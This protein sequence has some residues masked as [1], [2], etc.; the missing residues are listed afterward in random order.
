M[1]ALAA[2][3][4][5]TPVLAQTSAILRA[6]AGLTTPVVTPAAVLPPVAP[7][8]PNVAGMTSASARALANQ[9]AAT[10]AT[11]LAVQANA[12]ARATAQ[13]L[14][15]TVPNGL[16]A[17]GLVPVANAVAAA[18]DPTGLRTWQG[19]SAPVQS[20]SAATPTVTIT[21]TASRALLTWDSFNI[22]RNTTLEFKQQP[23]WVVV[24]RIV[25]N[26]DPATGRIAN[27]AALRPSQILG[28]IKAD[29]TV[30]VI[31]QNG[32]LFGGTA[33]INT[34][35]FLASS[36]E[37][38]AATRETQAAGSTL[39]IT[40]PNSIFERSIS[41]LQS[42]LL[43]SG[44]L[45][46]AVVLPNAAGNN[47]IEPSDTEGDVR[48]NAGASINSASGGYVIIAAPKVVNAGQLSST[49]GQVSLQS[50]RQ[51]LVSTS[52]GSSDSIDPEVRGLLLSSI[53]SS[54]DSISNEAT[55]LIDAKRGY[56]S[57]GSAVTGEVSNAGVLN[58]T[59]SVTRNGK[60]SITGS[61]VT[62]AT[63]STIVITPDN[64]GETIP[65]SAESV[66]AFKRSTINIGG[67][68][69]RGTVSPSRSSLASGTL[70]YA[71]SAKVNIGA[72]ND[73]ATVSVLDDSLS[74]QSSLAIASGATI[75][76]GGIKDL[77]VPAS[78]NSI[79]ISP[80]KRNELRDTPNY[81]ET[82]T[83]NS[84]T[85]NGAT[86]FVD[87][88]LSGVRADGVAWIG[89][90]LIEAGSFFAQVGVT[91]AE[92][93]TIG[94][95]LTLGVRSFA[96]G[97]NIAPASV[98]VDSGA[99]IDVSG[100]W[101][102]YEDGIVQ[103][104]RLRTADGRIVEIG[105]ADPNE[106]YVAVLD[107]I[108]VSQSRFGFTESFANTAQ[109][110]NFQTGYT[111]GRDAGSLTIKASTNSFG[112]VL[113]G[114]AFAGTRQ[115][116][117]AREASKPATIASDLR[118]LQAAPSQLPSGGLLKIA[119]IGTNTAEQAGGADIIVYGGATAPMRPA[120]EILLSDAFLSGAGLSQVALQ[121]SGRVSFQR[122]SA[123]TLQAGGALVVDAG[124]AINFDG[125]ISIAS[126]TIAARTY[127]V[128]PGS[129]F[130]SDDELPAVL[131][132]NLATPHLFDITVN[133]LLST[134]GRWTNDYLVS[135]GVY[136]GSA[137]AD[138]GSISLEVAPRV[139]VPV[140]ENAEFSADL[141][142]SLYVNASARIDVSGGGYVR[143]D[144]NLLIDS[145]GGNVAL[146]NQTTYSQIIAQPT[147][148]DGFPARSSA[149]D[150]PSFITT[151]EA[152]RQSGLAPRALESRVVIA[153][154]TIAGHGFS[155]GGNFTLVTPDLNFGARAGT[156]GTSLALDFVTKSGFGSFSLT[157][158]PTRLLSNVFSN[159]IGG[160]NAILDTEI[161]R[162]GSGETLNL[163]QSVINSL[164]VDGE[165]EAARNLVSGGDI[166]GLLGIAVPVDAFD[167]KAVDISFGGLTEVEIAAGGLVTG[168]NGASLSA[169]KLLNAGTIRISGGTVRQVAILPAAFVDTQRPAIG[170]TDL[171]TVFGARDANGLFNENADNALGIRRSSAVNAPVA[172]NADLVSLG[173]F[174]RPVYFTG[175]LAANEGIRLTAGSVTDLSGASIRNPRA[176]SRPGGEQKIDGRIVNGGRLETAARFVGAGAV[177][178]DVP[179]FGI[180]PYT[181]PQSGTTLDLQQSGMLLNAR[182]GATID[183]RGASDRYDFETAL[184]VFTLSPVW[185]DGGSLSLGSGGSL[186]GARV[187]ADGGAASAEGGVL[188][189]LD[190][191]LR[192]TDAPGQAVN[193][194][195]AD[196]IAAAG[197]DT[198]VAQNRLTTLG[199]ATLK[200]GR[201]FYLEARPFDG[202]GASIDQYRAVL[203]TTGNLSIEAPYIHLASPQQ[204]VLFDPF[205]STATG[206]ITLSGQTIDIIGSVYADASVANLTLNATGDVRLSG[207]QSPILTLIGTSTLPIASALSG[208]FVV[209]GDLNINAAQMYPTTGTGSLQ[210]DVNAQRAGTTAT[211]AP[212]VVASTGANA[213][214]RVSRAG[215]ST[216]ATPFSAGGNLLIQAANIVQDG[217]IRV[218]LGRLAIG[219]NT[220]LTLGS[221]LVSQVVPATRS[222]IIGANSTTSVS[223]NGLN[224]PYGTT[225]DLVEY[226]FTPTSDGRLFAP[227]AAELRLSGDSVDVRS[228]ASVDAT[229]G[230][231]LYAYEFAA[232][233]GGSR[234]VLS[235]FN[236]DPF[237]GN[238][239]FQ[240]AD[241]RQVYAIVPSLSQAGVALVDPVYSADYGALYNSTDAGRRVFLE[242]AP[243]LAAGW[244]T[245]LPAR[246]ALLPGGM[247]VVENVGE[248]PPALGQTAQ[249]RDG[250]LIVGGRY[251][252]T[253]TTIESSQRRT[254]TVQSQE[255]FRK[256]SN[257]QLTQASSTF[258]GLA[259]R[260]NLAVPRLPA[261]A[262]RL[263][264]APLTALAIN[265][266]F[267]TSPATGG[268]G[269]QVDISGNAFEIVVP[270]SAASPA[271]SIRLT[272]T[273]FSNLNAASLL[274]G[275][276][277]TENSNGTTALLV[278]SKSILVANNTANPLTAPEILLAVDG[279]DSTIRIAD[280][281]VISAT[282]SLND[283]SFGDYVITASTD[284]GQ[285]GIG[286]VMRL[287]NGAERL[288]SRPGSLAQA[289]SLEESSIT[290]GEARLTGQS[291]LLD[292]SRDL[293]IN[294]DPL[295]PGRAEIIATASLA[296]AGDDVFFTTAP[297]GYRGLVITPELEAQFANAEHLRIT[298]RSIIGF[299]GGTHSFKDLTID[300]RGVR[301][302]GQAITPPPKPRETQFDVAAADLSAPIGVTINARALKLAN[303][304]ISRT[305]CGGTATVTSCGETGNTLTVNATS[306]SFGSGGI[307]A[308]G[309][310]RNVLLSASQGVFIE[311]AATF[312]TGL[313]D[314]NVRSPYFGDRALSAD[315]RG[316]KVQPSLGVFTQGAVVLS[317]AGPA[318][319]A[320]AQA[321]GATL[322]FGSIDRPVA[323]FSAAGIALR[324]SAGV[325]DV[326]AVGDIVTTGTTVLATPGYSKTFGDAA[327][328]V[329]VSAP[330]GTL[331]LVSTRGNVNLGSASTLSIGGG[332]GNAGSLRLS[333]GLGTVTLPGVIEAAAPD[334]RA[335]LHFDSGL[336]G[337]DLA[338]FLA[339]QGKAFSGDIGIRTGVGNLTLNAGQ[340]LR[341]ESLRLTADGGRVDIAGTVD[342][343]GINGGSIG[344]FG[345]TGVTLQST[346]LLDSHAN[347]YPADDTR[348]ATGG[349]VEIGTVGTGNIVVASGARI[350]VAARRP[351]ARLI[352]QIRKDAQTL[353]D[354]LTYNYAQS[355]VG[356]T[357]SFRAPIVLTEVG[358]QS[359]NIA[360]AGTILGASETSVEGYRIFDLAT[361]ANPNGCA[362][363][364]ICINATGQAVLDLN[365]APLTNRL[366]AIAPG[367]IPDFIRSF[368]LSGATTGLGALLDD[369]NFRARPGV[370]L[371]YAGDIVLASN[372]NLAAATVN[373]AAATADGLIA[374]SVQLGNGLSY[375][376]PGKEAELFSG[377]S[378]RSQIFYTDFVYRVGG[379]ASGEAGVLTLRAGGNLDIRGSIT[380]GL[381]N[382]ADSTDPT[383]LSFQLGGGD[384]QYRPALVFNCG[385]F[386]SCGDLFTAFEFVPGATIPT[387]PAIDGVNI[388]I[389]RLTRG[390]DIT[391]LIGSPVAPYSAAA[392]SPGALGR[393]A[394]GAGDPIGSAV[395]MP[396]LADG[397]AAASSSLRLVGGAAP[398]GKTSLPVSADPLA[399]APSSTGSVI[400]SG[401]ATYRAAP[402]VVAQKYAGD[403]ELFNADPNLGTSVSAPPGDFIEALAATGVVFDPNTYTRL[404]LTGASATIRSFFV[405]SARAFFAANNIPANQ[406]QFFGPV[407]NP[408]VLTASADL[409]ARFLQSVSRDF[410]G[411]IG[412]PGFSY[413]APVPEAA[414]TLDNPNIATRSL[415][416]T[417]TG[418]IDIVA[419]RDVDLTNGRAVFRAVNGRNTSSTA[420]SGAQVGGAAVYTVGHRVDPAI[421]TATAVG[422]TAAL[423]IDPA[424]LAAQTATANFT[425]NL[426]GVLNSE[427]VYASGGGDIRIA[428][429]RDVIARRD[430]W[431]EAFRRTAA[432]N[433]P[434]PFANAGTD[435]QLWR[436]ISAPD[437]NQRFIP[438]TNIRINAQLFSTGVGAL[439]GGSVLIDAGRNISE[440][441]VASDTS[442]TTG[443][444]SNPRQPTQPA[445]LTLISF[446]GGNVEMRAGRDVL[447]AQVDV[448][449]G[450]LTIK[451]GNAVA[452]AGALRLAGTTSSP[453]APLEQNL[454]RVRLADATA[455][456][457][458]IK[459]V[460]IGGIASTDGEGF[461]ARTSGVSILT[462]GDALITNT[463]KDIRTPFSQNNDTNANLAGA[464]LPGS[465]SVSA[466]FGDINLSD[467]S[468]LSTGARPV[469]IVLV[470]SA[471]GQLRLFAGGH[472]APVT[473]V[474]DDGDPSL[475]PGPLSALTQASLLD[476]NTI[477]PNTRRFGVPVILPNTSDADRRLLHNERTTHAGD[478]EPV[479]IAADGNI[480]QLSLFVPKQ[481]RITA[482]GDIVDAIFV[483]QNLAANDVTR[484][485]AG[486]DIVASSRVLAT[487]TG[488]G[489][490]NLP[491]L[492]GN[493][494]VLGGPGAFFVEA[495]RDLG[496]FFNSA[497]VGDGGGN[498]LTYGG[499][500]L[501][502]GNDYNP[503]LQ[504][505]GAKLY[506]AFGVGKGA[507]YNALLSAYVDPAAS[508]DGDLFVQVTD[509]NGNTSPD[510]SKPI[511]DT[512]LVSW[513]V[514]NQPAAITAAFGAPISLA[515]SEVVPLLNSL[516]PAALASFLIDLPF[517]PIGGG[518]NSQTV[519]IDRSVAT[520]PVLLTGTAAAG[521]PSAQRTTISGST[522]IG[523]LAQNA[524]SVLM[525][526]YGLTS[527]D[528]NRAFAQLTA[529]PQLT[530]RQ[531]LL[532]RVYFNELAAPSRPDGAS[533]GQFIRGYRAVDLVFP[534]AS[535]YT[536]NDLAGAVNGGTKV[537]TGNLDLRLATLETQRGGD[538]T[539]LGPGGRVLG[540]SI[541]ATATQASRRGANLQ[542]PFNLFRGTRRSSID[543]ASAA[544]ILG[545]P[546]GFEGVLTLR[547]G[548]VRGFTDSDFLLNQSRLFTVGGGDITL[549]SSNG[550]LNA[551][552]G[553]KTSSNNPPVVVRFD[554]NGFGVLDQAGA[555]AGAGIAGFQPAGVD[556]GPDVT[557][558]A[559]V[560]T[561]D[562]GDAGVRAS[563]NVFVAAARV[564]N[565]DNFKVG[566]TA[567][568][569]IATTVVDTG[570]AASA[571][572]A[573]AAASQ[574]AAAVN[575]SSGR[576]GDDRSRI[577]VEVLGFAGSANDDPC[578]LPA[579]QRPGNCPVV[580]K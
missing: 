568:G 440:L 330:G 541:V 431:S 500:I 122:S 450:A 416:R 202:N 276:I 152:G 112:G 160:N 491:V 555:V 549:W 402:I 473:L 53:G 317:G 527:T 235:R 537:S 37:I 24:N 207:V 162:I 146:I 44:S 182:A 386:V 574:A 158:Y 345:L 2:A 56:I 145:K 64:N 49:E 459:T 183:V 209:A 367:T 471:V 263:V 342:T 220:P 38:G 76:V 92:L 166:A 331:S 409:M 556:K 413:A 192:Q 21:Q 205:S 171:G 13:A 153:P 259:T 557:L 28:T 114:D 427:P 457:S 148:P 472:L 250:S 35:S 533:S 338:A 247:R 244:Y 20:G 47:V 384:R 567:F 437:A 443:L 14:A 438:I 84:F 377:F 106:V 406:Y 494:F 116:A 301:P 120:S 155:G 376:V 575:P 154:G 74:L 467:T 289:N 407:N 493:N 65:Q 272:T 579:G 130:R 273:D 210:Q 281:A 487:P 439:G 353:N 497:I 163:T 564:A 282:G 82:T 156:S 191:V 321:P 255:T 485:T 571:N 231:D 316:T 232:G 143:P 488:T 290:I 470:P 319:T 42:G 40:V 448:A 10:N 534:G 572:A 396:L 62:L 52:S 344:L 542:D 266:R 410:A 513:L 454:L 570:A 142:G 398:E 39:N 324:A 343:S 137:Y 77:V 226:L 94:G 326:R 580:Q 180:A 138:G 379:R 284:T 32:I 445:A 22:G 490:A 508:L 150:A 441:T 179:L 394:N 569:N 350:D 532:D 79:Q 208:Q 313:A 420:T 98:M 332:S 529:L 113:H 553:V 43:A 347:G 95:D 184:G 561:V 405:T 170:V 195:S 211:A 29:G 196:Q 197:F 309:F 356:G 362:S 157:T 337:L 48:I 340:T 109:T 484:I 127:V 318:L 460:T 199:N 6:S 418:A 286:G 50:G 248:T 315:P 59:T 140:G 102:R 269:A 227:P 468:L 124:R 516:D 86:L 228:G 360:Y 435:T 237:S 230:G 371:E 339:G 548:S 539:I 378:E 372:W 186:N 103:T 576:A 474:M 458:A 436:S 425:P 327:D 320:V 219:S 348:A 411:R 351:G 45:V 507:N 311:G 486:G 254:F 479:R 262:A 525:A 399:I 451:A 380:D 34:R 111:E 305:P 522:L 81:R 449:S 453:I 167:R 51:V 400:V 1:A 241:G 501:T 215:T 176:G 203:S 258:S 392:N 283:T 469:P 573:S 521:A 329:I 212:Y 323:S 559:P 67:A 358:K 66:A 58:S 325:L 96:Q 447:G 296:I 412:A 381:F 279:V 430:A 206:R 314:L 252:I 89:S 466:L 545:I 387:V 223:A 505:A 63:G 518:I 17:G 333:A 175:S 85:L 257:I 295:T 119:A 46:S 69:V 287:A 526:R 214:I 265:T 509:E 304:D 270:G 551:G 7:V 359:V 12:A 117:D 544:R 246:Y 385:A 577:T 370:Q 393:Q 188:T 168:S 428:S 395:I 357:V 135:N 18:L 482:G 274:I 198:F 251:G 31:N 341:A 128:V 476:I 432:G 275:G 70:I 546:T 444:V 97:S 506:V 463:G 303:S 204:Q 224:I 187:F 335:S 36:L 550:D 72:T 133:G 105:N 144:G 306:I 271:G 554:P 504:P 126:G 57:M 481:A 334:G 308:F 408:T 434:T 240:F 297:S 519:A 464:L 115:I 538:I 298:T 19:A 233:I 264:L 141:S 424:F 422:S 452:S 512:A 125:S 560:G 178:A 121:T 562:A 151:P 123:L 366:A 578:N 429:G 189:W 181:N 552:Q 174:S 368:N 200:L 234:D 365:A 201:G 364:D 159:G 446:G 302:Y 256:F 492:Q 465:F 328:Q 54:P 433:P 369:P 90:P 172:T 403:L 16:V 299:S 373:V 9:V 78:R 243:G 134:R 75:D 15:Q 426:Q 229:G 110:S 336:G 310:D 100:G 165:I 414:T 11:S 173:L 87:P 477:N 388:V 216:P 267:L 312:D 5:H 278:T 528:I 26:I 25:A 495:G 355:D 239:G 268:R 462:N 531:F 292:S 517:L 236:A 421:Q 288:V 530:Q 149:V 60:I 375:V 389:S 139:L 23:D 73:A 3:L 496:P 404:T 222:T 129:V 383:Y 415:I 177:F 169:T 483:G 291:I 164:L 442:V 374:P 253:G 104:S 524:P 4:F 225:T 293:I 245:L 417:G 71:P 242:A 147:I 480:N 540:G 261:D 566:G 294:N 535:G 218:P 80:A 238:D 361:M 489:S 33:Q 503:W 543:N 419:A 249:L 499:G 41:Y 88:R 515:S 213:I 547:G 185:S 401:E 260:D 354:S 68:E 397:S 99:V 510:T 502:V 391:D 478:T 118:K 217:V 536:K 307:G 300:A 558:V 30:L 55:G 382:F 61:R 277:R 8:A 83:D 108:T 523:W 461:Y 514:E 349:R 101:V 221:S 456:I 194:V 91:A 475:T 455:S 511:Y 107:S 346:A 352:S 563:G 131:G 280:G 565:A 161:V 136:L 285:T 93:M 498:L 390:Q 193:V 363:A 520:A 132:A 190:P 27:P 322:A 423:S